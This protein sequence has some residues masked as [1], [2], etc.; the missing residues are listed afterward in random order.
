M[1]NK[2]IKIILTII[3]LNLS[4]GTLQSINPVSEANAITHLP[5]G[6]LDILHK[7]DDLKFWL[8]ILSRGQETQISWLENI[9]D[10]ID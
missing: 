2:Y 4:I 5:E 8:Q 7:I 9:H 10:K 1:T 3:A 6:N